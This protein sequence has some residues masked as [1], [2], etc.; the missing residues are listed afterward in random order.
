MR[1]GGDY[2]IAPID[3]FSVEPIRHMV[4]EIAATGAIPVIIGTGTPVPGGFT[5]REISPC[6]ADAAPRTT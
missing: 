1:A 2:E 6:S 5:P 3:Q 4:R